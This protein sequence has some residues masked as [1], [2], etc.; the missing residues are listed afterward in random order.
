MVVVM[1]MGTNAAS[2]SARSSSAVAILAHRRAARGAD[3][4]AVCNQ[5]G[6]KD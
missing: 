3:V 1:V 2:A 6:G 5:V 4:P